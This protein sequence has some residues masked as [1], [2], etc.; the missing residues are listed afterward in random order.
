MNDAQKSPLF[1]L[2]ALLL[3]LL[4]GLLGAQAFASEE[5]EELR[6]EQLETDDAVDGDS[7]HDGDGGDLPALARASGLWTWV[8]AAQSVASQAAPE[9]PQLRAWRFE[10]QRIGARGPPLS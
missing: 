7:D 8:H 6:V 4:P 1:R 3:L 5:G 2:L 9:A 10:N